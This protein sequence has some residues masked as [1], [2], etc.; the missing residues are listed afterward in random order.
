MTDHCPAC[1]F[2]GC[3]G[4]EYQ[5]GANPV[6]KRDVCYGGGY[7]GHGRKDPGTCVN[8]PGAWPNRYPKARRFDTMSVPTRAAPRDPF[9]GT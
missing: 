3:P 2:R 9:G 7:A 4:C 1:P 8:R 6:A 5:G